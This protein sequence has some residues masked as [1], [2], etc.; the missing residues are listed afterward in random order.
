MSKWL[1]SVVFFVACSDESGLPIGGTCGDNG[2]CS[3]GLC[4]E[5]VCVDPAGDN[6]NDTLINGLEASLGTDHQ[7]ADSDGDG[8]VDAAEVGDVGAPTDSDGDGRIDATESALLDADSD[9]VVDELDPANNDPQVPGSLCESNCDGVF[10]VGEACDDG[11]DVT[12]DG[13][14]QCEV[15]PLPVSREGR[16]PRIGEV[17]GLVSGGFVSTWHEGASATAGPTGHSVAF[18]DANGVELRRHE[19]IRPPTSGSASFKKSIAALRGGDVVVSSVAIEGTNDIRVEVRRYTDL[20][21]PV[22]EAFE[23][24]RLTQNPGQIEVV[25]VDAGAY[26]LVHLDNQRQLVIRYVDA[27]GNLNANARGRILRGTDV[28]F[29]VAGFSDGSV[30]VV[31]H[32]PDNAGTRTL[33]AKR[34]PSTGEQLGPDVAVLPAGLTAL[35]YD[36]APTRDGYAVFFTTTAEPGSRVGYRRFSAADTAMGDVVILHELT[37]QTTCFNEVDGGFHL[38]DGAYVFVRDTCAVSLRAWLEVDDGVVALSPAPTPDMFVPRAT[39]FAGGLVFQF[40][41][42]PQEGVGGVYLSRFTREGEPALLT[43]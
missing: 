40:N 1:W 18:F 27:A 11:N 3:S 16:D 21:E 33:S 22:G 39:S 25:A 12:T 38:A 28:P 8:K 15:V 10:E 32:E 30:V 31:S 7:Q 35:S 29:D 41:H 19:D 26:A 5:A 34:F 23:A 14:D 9:C 20:G 2:E 6:D 36:I 4:L 13:C 24:L 43:R 17:A 42:V 37:S